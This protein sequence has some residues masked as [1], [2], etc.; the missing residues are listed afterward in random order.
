ML[1]SIY[2]SFFLF[3]FSVVAAA[4]NPD[5]ITL[6]SSSSGEDA[7][8][9][10]DKPVVSSSSGVGDQKQR[11][12]GPEARAAVPGGRYPWL[13]DDD[14]GDTAIASHD[15]VV[16]LRRRPLLLPPPQHA[17]PTNETPPTTTEQPCQ[18]SSSN[19]DELELPSDDDV[20]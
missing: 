2:H 1:C 20:A 6:D 19:P 18:P 3:L 14:N 8:G 5:E 7:D 9:A 10:R 17:P 12:Q 4:P 16:S 15:V 13:D 11:D